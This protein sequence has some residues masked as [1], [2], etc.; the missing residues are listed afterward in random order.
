MLVPGSQCF[1]GGVDFHGFVRVGY[2]P[3][4]EVM[5]DGLQALR[6]FMR[7]EHEKLPLA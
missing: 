5:V 6:K 4:H 1:G 7:D 3:E 2:V